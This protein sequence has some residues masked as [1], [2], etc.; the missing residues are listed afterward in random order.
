V[1]TGSRGVTRFP[2]GI[3]SDVVAGL[4]TTEGVHD[5]EFRATDRLAR[6]TI[7]ARCFDLHLRA[8][9][10]ELESTSSSQP[11]KVHAY[12]LDSL[13]LAPGARYDQIAP[14]LLNDDATGASLIDQDV[15]NGTTETIYLT[16]TVTRPYAVMVAQSFVLSNAT[17]NVKRATCGYACN[18]PVHG[19]TY[20]SPN[21]AVSGQE[22]A[23]P[24]PVKVFEL[25]SGVPTTEIP[26]LAPCPPSGTVFKFA[27][28]PRAS[29]GQPARAFRV[30]TMIGQVSNLWPRD[31]IREAAP[32]FEDAAITWKDINSGLTTT[33]RLTGIVDRTYDPYRTG[34]VKYVY[35]PDWGS[36]CAEEA[37]IVPYRAL[38][39]ATLTFSNETRTRYET[40]A[41]ASLTPAFAKEASRPALLGWTTSE[42]VLP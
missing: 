4:A 39:S 13:S 19:P 22:I 7:A 17:T 31:Q 29:G 42:G 5:V 41:T 33:T 38:R 11:T 32:P 37:T 26:C 21:P 10:L 1:N 28:P 6:T 36:V 40:A 14:R 20:I 23:L 30:M 12:A 16:A 2:V 18:P 27:I 24:F 35:D 3:F 34:C 8:P 15:F 9:P 25:V